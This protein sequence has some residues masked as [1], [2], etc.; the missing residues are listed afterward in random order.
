MKIG[1][2]VIHK[3]NPSLGKGVIISF[4]AFQGTILVRWESSDDYGYVLPQMIKLQ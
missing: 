3:N 1:D 2:I 4:Q